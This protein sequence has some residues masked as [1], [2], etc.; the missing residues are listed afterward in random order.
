MASRNFRSLPIGWRTVICWQSTPASGL[1]RLERT[2]SSSAPRVP[3]SNSIKKSRGFLTAPRS[4]AAWG[5]SGLIAGLGS[6]LDSYMQG[7]SVGAWA[8]GIG[9]VAG[10]I[11]KWSPWGTAVSLGI[12]LGQNFGA[13][14]LLSTQ[15][16]NDLVNNL[17]DWGL[18]SYNSFT[19]S[20]DA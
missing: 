3:F 14:L 19:N 8:S 12:G 9:T 20:G 4:P 7:D 1:G 16:G 17:S 2:P 10:A 18:N 11:P 13:P 15:W 6:T 5:M